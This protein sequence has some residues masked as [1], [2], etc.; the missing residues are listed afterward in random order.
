MDPSLNCLIKK[1]NRIK[2]EASDVKYVYENK[3][4]VHPM[5]EKRRQI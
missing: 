1:E 3:I 2:E 4:Y 5:G